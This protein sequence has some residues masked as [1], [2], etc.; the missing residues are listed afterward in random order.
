MLGLRSL[1]LGS[2]AF[3]SLSAAQAAVLV[4]V[5]AVPNSTS[6]TVFG[7]NS[8]NVLAGSFIGNDGIEH[9]FFG[10]NGNYATFD[11]GEG[12]TQARGISDDGLI[13]GLSNSQ[14]GDAG[15]EP[16]FE[17]QTDGTI[18]SVTRT[19]V[20]LTG[21]AQGFSNDDDKFAG[22]YWNPNIHQMVA[23][24]GQSGKWRSD[25]TISDVHQASVARGMNSAGTVVGSYFKPP[26]HG[27]IVANETLTIVDYPAKRAIATEL[28]GINDGGVAVGQWMDRKGLTHSF[29]LDTASNAFTDIKV[30]GA[31]EVKAWG[32]NAAGAVALDT[33]IGAF[34]WC[35]HKNACPK[36]G[37]AVAAPVHRLKHS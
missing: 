14:S 21:V 15:A 11:A 20:S 13:T 35:Q 16:I 33:D 3:A 27:F 12:G 17:R 24:V 10:T 8:D 5:A 2:F 23:F 19:G 22:G 26:Q 37:T 29:V 34:I 32:I 18:L 28:E 6:T 1:L 7:I 9:G 31:T 4:P 36:G 30:K 25:V